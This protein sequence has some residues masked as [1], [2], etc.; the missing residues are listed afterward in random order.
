MTARKYLLGVCATCALLFSLCV[1]QSA[2]AVAQ[3]AYKCTNAAGGTATGPKRFSDEH[4][5]LDA[6]PTGQ[7]YHE[8]IGAGVK[9]AATLTNTTTG[10]GTEPLKLKATVGGLLDTI[11]AQTVTASGTIENNEAG[12][13]MYAEF[14]TNKI[15][16][17]G[18]S[19]ARECDVLGIP[20]GG[21][22]AT[23]NKIE[24]EPIKITTKGQAAG[25][26]TLS[27]PGGKLLEFELTGAKCPP[28]L[29][30]LY[31]LLG[32]AES[33]AAEGATVPFA[34]NTV[35]N[36]PNPKLRYRNANLGPLVG[37]EGKI[38]LAAVKP[39]ALT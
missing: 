36:E 2:M 11:T 37:L 18:L 35:T 10:T 15:T 20:P 25:K 6:T 16:I 9:V 5:K 26:V 13:E 38:T 19:D 3:T 23:P 14:L 27:A 32:N 4:C 34:H 39:L 31:P 1:T 7:F 21:G 17:E 24:S 22:A 28:A 30:G 33:S 29:E 12:G 8:E